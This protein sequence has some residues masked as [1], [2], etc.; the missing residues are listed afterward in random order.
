MA[1]AVATATAGGD[2]DPKSFVPRAEFDR[3]SERLNTLETGTA[4]AKATAAVD[5]ANDRIGAGSSLTVLK[6]PSAAR[7]HILTAAVNLFDSAAIL[8]VTITPP[9]AAAKIQL[10]VY[11]PYSGGTEE[12]TH[13]LLR[14][15]TPLVSGHLLSGEAGQGNLDSF[16]D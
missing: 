1:Q 4:E 5:A 14:D 6:M 15:G 10:R 7:A 12:G 3:V 2:P 9:S 16:M 13:R 11:L 8:S